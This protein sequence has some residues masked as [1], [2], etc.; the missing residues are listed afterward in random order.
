MNTE[1]ENSVSYLHVIG[2]GDLEE[3]WKTYIGHGMA[4]SMRFMLGY[5]PYEVRQK[6]K[7]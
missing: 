7:L 3:L 4:G 5:I 6:D 1:A 2:F